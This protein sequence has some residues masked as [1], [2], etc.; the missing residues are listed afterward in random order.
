MK[1][2]KILI[3]LMILVHVS[4]GSNHKRNDSLVISKLDSIE[5]MLDSL[6]VEEK[7]YVMSQAVY[8][9]HWFN[10]TDCSWRYNNMFGFKGK[11]GKYLK[12]KNWREGVEYYAKWQKERYLKYKKK[13]PRGTY[14]GFLKW[15]KFAVS[16]DYD[17]QIKWMHDWVINNC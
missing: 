13:Y 14:I 16:D 15:C 4:H 10:C 1:K 8:E 11:N 5:A 6:G 17:R 9:S 12:F 2:L 7:F 3:L